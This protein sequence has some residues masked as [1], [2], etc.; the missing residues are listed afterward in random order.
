MIKRQVPGCFV[1]VE[2]SKRTRESTFFHQINTAIDWAVFEKELDNVCKRSIQDAASR[3]SYHPLVLFKMWLLPTRYHLS[4]VGVEDMVPDTMSANAFC[5]LRVEDT[6]PDHSTLSRFRSAL[7][8]KRA[9]HRLLAQL[10]AQLAHQGVLVQQGGG[11]IDASIT[12]TARKPQGRSTDRLKEYPDTPLTKAVKPGA[13]QE[14]RWVKKGSKLHYGYK[15][16]DL[17][18]EDTG[19][20]LAVHTTA[21]NVPDGQ[22][23]SSCLDQVELPSESRILA[24]TGY[25]SAKNGQLLRQRG[26][27]SGIQRKAYRH[28]PLSVWEKCYNKLIGRSWYQIER[29]FGSIK[30]WLGR[31][32]A[33]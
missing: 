5:G 31:L 22:C 4:D 26:L 2:V 23:I 19:L 17:A 33:R 10:N 9:M 6:V 27:R 3:P 13:D 15:R 1:S 11:I 29:V 12:P 20:V 30:R 25:C 7:S 18:A 14:A 8:A 32:E 16:H 28:K 24:D 21:A